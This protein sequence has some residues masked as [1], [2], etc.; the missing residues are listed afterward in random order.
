LRLPTIAAGIH[1]RV[2]EMLA[3]Q[4]PQT[5]QEP[6]TGTGVPPTDGTFL[7]EAP[8]S[9]NC[10]ILLDGRQVQLTLRDTDESRLL[11]RLAAVLKQYPQPQAPAQASSQGESRDKDWCAMHN[12]PMHENTKQGRVWYSHR[13][14]D[15]QWCK[16]KARR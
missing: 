7:P 8:A 6:T 1:K 14:A 10:H 5:A 2:Q 3:A 9:V 12:V 4:T 16:G 15:G 13:T 11:E